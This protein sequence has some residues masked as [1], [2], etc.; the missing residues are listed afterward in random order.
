MLRVVSIGFRALVCVLVIVIGVG[1]LFGLKSM[2]KPPAQSGKAERTLRVQVE[3]V[4]FQDVRVTVTGM[5]EVRSKDILSI[6]PEV[7]GRI[8]QIHP[9]LEVGEII[10]AGEVLFEIDPRDYQAR[11]DESQANI[12]QLTSIVSRLKKQF[13]IDE[14]RLKTYKRSKK[15]SEDEYGRVKKLYTE[16]K[17]G[18]QSQVDNAEMMFNNSND[19]YDQLSQALDLFPIRIQEAESNLA[20]VTSMSMLAK[21]SLERTKVS[22]PFAAR[23][24]TVQVEQGQYV[25]PG[26]PV[27]SLADDSVLEISIPLGSEN[28]RKW[29]QFDDSQTKTGLAWFNG[30]LQVPVNVHWEGNTWTGLLHRVEKFERQTDQLYVVVRLLGTEAVNPVEGHMPLVE[31]MFCN[32][33]IPGQVVQNV[34]QVPSEAVGFEKD[35]QGYQHIFV[36]SESEDGVYRLKTTRVLESHKKGDYSYISEGLNDGDY[37]ITTRLINPLENILLTTE[38]IEFEETD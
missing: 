16:Q 24:K 8:V 4:R 7:S 25:T 11:Y 28:A 2:R 37:V 36:A 21:T 31:G 13:K 34:V 38:V 1:I 29:I 33:E 35:E 12:S 9:K 17:V 27:V 20:S 10:P 19:L 3:K 23:V 5:G 30:L 32:V 26:A 14:E 15:L 6:A 18:T 22:V